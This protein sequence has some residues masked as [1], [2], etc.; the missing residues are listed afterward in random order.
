M[1]KPNPRDLQNERIKKF[2][3]QIASLQGAE[4]SL[5]SL[6]KYEEICI[7]IV[8]EYK[9]VCMLV[10]ACVKYNIYPR[11]PEHSPFCLVVFHDNAVH[12]ISISCKIC[13]Q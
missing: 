1:T 9:S 6:E 5:S 13:T 2:F 4:R 3:E 8:V 7:I 10:M 11:G 12:N